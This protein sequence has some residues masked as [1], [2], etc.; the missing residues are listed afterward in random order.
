MSASQRRQEPGNRKTLEKVRK[1]EYEL[2]KAEIGENPDRDPV[3]GPAK[4]GTAGATVIGVLP[5]LK[6][7]DKWKNLLSKGL[8]KLS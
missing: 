4:L 2:L 7:F 1:G 6:S 3:Y 8:R 5:F